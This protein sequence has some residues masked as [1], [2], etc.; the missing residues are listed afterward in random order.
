MKIVKSK[1]RAS[2]AGPFRLFK[3]YGKSK[4]IGT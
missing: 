4:N 2:R 1:N 3:F